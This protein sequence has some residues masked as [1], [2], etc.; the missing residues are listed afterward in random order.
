MLHEALT[1]AERSATALQV[2]NMPWLNRVDSRLARR[3]RR[4]RSREIFVVEDHAPVGA[5]GDSLRR[6]PR[7]S[8]GHRVR[9]RGLARLR[10]A[11]GGAPLPRSRRRLARGPHR[12][13]AAA[14]APRRDAGLARPPGPL[15]LATLLR[16]RHRRRPARAAGRPAR[17]LSAR[18]ERARRSPGASAQATRASR[19]PGPR[20]P[21]T[22]RR[23]RRRSAASTGWLD[24]RVGF[25]PLS[26]RQSLQARL[27]PRTHAAGPSELVPRSRRSPARCPLR[28]PLDPALMRWHYG[29]LRYVPRAAPRAAAPRAAGGRAREHPDA[30][31]RPLHRRRAASRCC[32]SSVTSRAGTTRSARGS[33]SPHL[34]RYIVQNDVMRSDLVRYHGIDDDRIVVT[35]WPQTDVFH[36]K[37]PRED[38]ERVVRGLGLDPSRPVVLVMGNT[39]DERSVRA[40][41]SSSGSSA[42]GRRAVPS[43]ASRSCSVRIRATASGGSASPPRCS[44]DGRRG[45][46][47]E[48]HRPRDACRPAPARRLSSSR[49]RA[50]SCSTRS[51][52]TGRRS[53][54]STTRARRRA[55]AGR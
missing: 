42:G 53:A 39:P 51:S 47:A 24:R 43:R 52:T 9:R 5:L 8:A 13:R 30:R 25:Y 34:R 29:R 22:S 37:R 2:V 16:H 48:L 49:T 33:S 50:R 26:L 18:H 14:P 20:V 6:A 36:R 32:R 4:A 40:A 55:R 28:A 7:R 23:P 44:G 1:A 31:R 45:S 21:S 54:C 41:R 27:Q 11:A 3:A 46:G 19:G 17:A 38:Y 10:D 12:A 15:L 35:G